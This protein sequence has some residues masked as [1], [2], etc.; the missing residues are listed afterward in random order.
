MWTR[1]DPGQNSTARLSDSHHRGE[2]ASAYTNIQNRLSDSHHRGEHA[3]ANAN[4]QSTNTSDCN[5]QHEHTPACPSRQGRQLDRC[6]QQK[7]QEVFDGQEFVCEG[8]E[9]MHAVGD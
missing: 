6:C 8:P 9:F 5:N 1:K 4:I 7:V 3:S 2:H